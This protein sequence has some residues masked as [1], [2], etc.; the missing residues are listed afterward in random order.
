MNDMY[1]F[2][3]ESSIQ[4]YNNEILE[5]KIDNKITRA[6]ANPTENYL[7]EFNYMELI[8]NS[9]FEINEN[10]DQNIMLKYEVKD[11]KIHQVYE[12]INDETTTI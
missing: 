10:E 8:E 7:K 1:L 12:V 2:I 3:N 9:S 5:N 6:I 4:K 11:G